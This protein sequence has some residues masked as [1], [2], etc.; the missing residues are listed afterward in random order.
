MNAK[1]TVSGTVA[2]AVIALVAGAAVGYYVRFFTEKP[3][4]R[5][6]VGAMAGSGMGM[7][8]GSGMGMPMMG[9]GGPGA[10]PGGGG[11]MEL[12]RLV[13]N[14]DVLQQSQGN[15]LTA[16]Q[17]KELKPIL[18]S[19]KTAKKIDAATAS[20]DVDH[21]Q[22]L[23]TPGQKQVMELMAPPGRGG[24][25]GGRPGPMFGGSAM[26]GMMGG[27]QGGPSGAPPGNAPQGPMMGTSAMGAMAGGGR[28]DAEHPFASDRNAKA[29]DDLIAAASRLAP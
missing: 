16:A 26:G 9:G 15:G 27:P 4:P 19:I 6:P 5:I 25:P 17:A 12:A 28:P 1:S 11:G 2:A 3:L 8:G 22:K 20:A 18:Q 24:A 21:I 29:L 14:L 10:Q 13:R 23:L 7:M